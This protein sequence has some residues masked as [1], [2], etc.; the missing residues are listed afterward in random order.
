[1][2]ETLFMIADS[3]PIPTGDVLFLYDPAT[4]KDLISD[5]ICGALKGSTSVDATFQIDGY[6]TL[7]FAA[8][9]AG[10]VLTFPTALSLNSMTEWTIEWSSRPTTI[11][12]AYFTELFLDTVPASGIPLGCR[13]T[14]SGYGDK[15]QFNAADF[16]NLRLWRAAETKASAVNKLTRYSMVYK[17]GAIR[18]YK[19]GVLQMLANGVEGGSSTSQTF[20]PKTQAWPVFANLTLGWFN[21][22]NT[23]W[24]GN[25]GRIRISN[26]ARYLANYT[27]APF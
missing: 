10:A 9:S 15:M 19:D 18:V 24:L 25:F 4:N 13:W 22:G 23:A 14:D 2:I 21:A 6:D 3:T 5:T 26:F 7:K 12:S 27:P 1:M 8:A 11:G 20:I 16:N 17:G